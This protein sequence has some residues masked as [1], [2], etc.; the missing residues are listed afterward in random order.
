MVDVRIFYV[1]STKHSNWKGWKVMK[2]PFMHRSLS[3]GYELY[4]HKCLELPKPLFTVGKQVS[5]IFMKGIL[6]TFENS[7]GFPVF[8]QDPT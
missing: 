1:K 2:L 7:T 5:F 8:R 4:I 3:I 6:L